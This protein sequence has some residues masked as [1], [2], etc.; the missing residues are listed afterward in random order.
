[1]PPEFDDTLS[2]PAR[3]RQARPHRGV[4][5][6][7]I[8]LASLIAVV[9]TVVLW[10]SRQ[11]LQTKAWTE[12]S[13]KLLADDE[14][15]AALSAYLVD[16]LFNSVDVKA[17][18]QAALPPD[19]QGLAVPAT[20][21][22][23]TLAGRATVEALK[24]P[25]VQRLWADANRV[26]HRRMMAIL[27]GGREVLPTAGGAVT[28]DLVPI[29][30]QIGAR[31]GLDVVGKVP[32]GV[33]TIDI[34]QSRQLA[35]AQILARDLRLLGIILPFL[36]LV[37]LAL[38]VYLAHGWRREALEGV[39][40]AFLAA[41]LITL[42][43]RGVTGAAAIGSMDLAPSIEPVAR[44]VWEVG[45]SLLQSS[46]FALIG[47]GVVILLGAWLAGPSRTATRVRHGMAPV[48]RERRY[49]YAALAVI[50]VL[51]FW[52]NP[53]PG[54]ERILPSLILIALAVAGLEALR[55]ASLGDV[56]PERWEPPADVSPAARRKA[57]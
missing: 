7:I 38:A 28:L 4:V 33:G 45:T 41:G 50:L 5:V 44:S 32:E 14:I 25:L 21:G 8:I 19:A 10:A 48:L 27:R 18:L 37:P 9:A 2:G 12:T 1:M 53:T 22:L 6:T 23:R 35:R 17:E 46:A 34:L 11:A 47:Y 31:V 15:N 55:A 39:G 49:T 3:S 56:S 30:E 24:R 36:A 54:T 16:A 20:A 29:V 26:A 13:V 43:V 51:V 42:V 57:G 52:W 40:F